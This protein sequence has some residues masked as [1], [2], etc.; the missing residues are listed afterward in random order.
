MAFSF[1]S[2]VFPSL[3]LQYVTF[4]WFAIHAILFHCCTVC[5][6]LQYTS[7]SLT[8]QR[9]LSVQVHCRGRVCGILLTSIYALYQGFITR[10]I[11]CT[12]KGGKQFI[13][14]RKIASKKFALDIVI[15][16]VL[17]RLF[18]F[19]CGFDFLAEVHLVEIAEPVKP[20]D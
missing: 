7:L 13:F 18:H 16:L 8:A 4:L 20:L 10:K 2:C 9:V 3:L 15:S 12:I 14:L 6:D 5:S 17:C 1:S 19:I 11:N